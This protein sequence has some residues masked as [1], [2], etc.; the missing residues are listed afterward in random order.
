M[1]PIDVFPDA[2]LTD[3]GPV[4]R[5]F[6]SL[7]LASFIEVCRYVHTMPYGY[8]TSREPLI[9]LRENRG[10]CT[11]KHMAVGLLAEELGLPIHKVHRHLCHG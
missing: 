6:R 10:S 4:S 1:D 7:G 8:N 9:L 11:T 2:A 5:A 3:S